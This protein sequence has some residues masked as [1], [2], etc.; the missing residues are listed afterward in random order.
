MQMYQTSFCCCICV[1]CYDRN[2]KAQGIKVT[3]LQA[4]GVPIDSQIT[5]RDGLA[6]FTANA[7]G[8]YVIKVW[9]PHPAT[10]RAY[11]CRFDLCSQE[12]EHLVF[13]FGSPPIHRGMGN[14]SILLVDA[15]YPNLP[16]SGGVYSLW[17]TS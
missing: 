8:E 3:F 13:V 5:Q 7:P 16:L 9:S 1:Q 2:R 4:D 12:P 6:V 14:A 10:P 15:F 11:Y 17:Q